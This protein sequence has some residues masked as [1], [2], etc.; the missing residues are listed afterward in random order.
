ML[1]D[2]IGDLRFVDPATKC[3]EYFVNRG[4]MG[5][6]LRKLPLVPKIRVDTNPKQNR[7][8]LEVN[9]N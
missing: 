8:L 9:V 1:A 6:Y 7:N 4:E 3:K 2:A 5:K